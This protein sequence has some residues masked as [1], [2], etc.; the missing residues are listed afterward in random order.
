MTIMGVAKMMMTPDDD[1]E[2]IAMTNEHQ[3]DDIEEVNTLEQHGSTTESVEEIED[4]D[5][6]NSKNKQMHE[7]TKEDEEEELFN[8]MDN[9]GLLTD[10]GK[11]LNQSGSDKCDVGESGL[12]Q[13]V[14]D[15]NVVQQHHER[16]E[17]NEIEGRTASSN[18]CCIC[19]RSYSTDA[20]A[21]YCENQH[22]L[23][24]SDYK[25]LECNKI[26]YTQSHLTAHLQNHSIDVNESA[27]EYRTLRCP[28]CPQLVFTKS[29]LNHHFV[30]EH[31]DN[32]N[33]RTEE[34]EEVVKERSI[35]GGTKHDTKLKG[36]KP[37]AR[38]STA[39]G[40]KF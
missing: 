7:P 36:A 34:V 23:Y 39:G 24:A 22:A 29:E 20:G 26:C 4:D 10:T 11:D 31:D 35:E 1:I 5:D 40:R 8:D 6:N 33:N 9:A 19:K 30:I 21:R 17:Q 18:I 12:A 32:G 38:K 3:D 15:P 16:Q 25:C 13:I 28:K 14:H 37:V 2:E 27:Y